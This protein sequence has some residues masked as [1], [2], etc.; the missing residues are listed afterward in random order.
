M[1][2]HFELSDFHILQNLGEGSFSEVKL[3]KRKED[4]KILALKQVQ[5]NKIS[6]E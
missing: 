1:E 4:G 3:V 5:M 6:E 2:S